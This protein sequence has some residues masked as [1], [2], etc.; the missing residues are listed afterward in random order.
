MIL[1]K[2]PP[3]GSAAE[4]KLEAYESLSLEDQQWIDNLAYEVEVLFNE[5]GVDKARKHMN[6]AILGCDGDWYLALWWK[7]GSKTRSALKR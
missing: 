1:S 3:S 2:R 4:I 7:L 6:D 5:E